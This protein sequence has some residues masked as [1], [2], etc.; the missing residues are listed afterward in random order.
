MS[1]AL[2]A[3]IVAVLA[4]GGTLGFAILRGLRLYRDFRGFLKTL[5]RAVDDVSLT[6]ERLSAYEAPETEALSR[7]TARLAESRARLSLLLG[8]IGRVRQQWT[9]LAAVYPRK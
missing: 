1:L 9:G 2:L 6:L 3:L 7:S 5:G 4:V 8:A